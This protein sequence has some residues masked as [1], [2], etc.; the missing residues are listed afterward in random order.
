MAILHPVVL[1][2]L[3]LAAMFYIQFTHCCRVGFEAV[4]D[5]PFCLTVPLQRFAKELQSRPFVAFLGD[6]TLEDLA[7]VVHCPPQIVRLS[8]DVGY[9]ALRVTNISSR[10]QR[11]WRKPLILEIRC[12]LISDANIGPNRFHH[13]LTVS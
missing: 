11:H 6:I 10:C 12:L 8:I 9:A 13:I 2:S 5:D 7:S 4:G 3:Y 1:L